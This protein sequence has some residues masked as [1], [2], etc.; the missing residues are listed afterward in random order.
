MVKNYF[1]TAWRNLKKSKVYSF[2][3]I[4]GLAIGMSV[5][6]IIGLWVWDELSFDKVHNNY[7]RIAQAWQFVKFDV[8]KSAYNSMPIPLAEELRTKYADFEAVSVSTYN[9]DVI[10][11]SGE[12]KIMRMGM[13]VEQDFP[14]MMTLKMR[15][16]VYNALSDMHSIFISQSLA[17]ALFATENPVNKI[18]RLNNKANVKI[19]GVYEDFPGNSSFKDVFFLAS[20]QLFTT[21]D[22]YA[23]Y[24]SDQWDE[25]SFQIFVQLKEGVDI[26]KLSA[27][28]K[29]IRMKRDNPPGYKPEFFLHPMSK[30][31]LHGDFQ[32]GVNTGGLIKIVRLFGFAGIFILLLACIN[33]MNLSTAR[34]EKRAKEVGIRKTL[35]SMRSQLVRQFFSESLLVS[36]IALLL[37]LIIAQLLLPFFNKIADKNMS[38]LWTNPIFWLSAIAFCLLAGLIAGSYPA[39]YLS[40][41]RPVKVLKGSFKAGRLASLPRKILVVFQ[42]TISVALI[43]GTIVVSRQI[44]F[45]KQRPTGYDNNGLIEVA[46]NTPDLKGHYEAIRA[47]LLNTGAV[48]AVSESMGYIVSDYGGTTNISWKGKLPDARPLI[49]RNA[50]THDFGKTIGWKIIEGRD[51]S[52]KFPTDTSAMILNQTAVQLM[53]FKDPLNEIVKVAGKDYRVIAVV[54]NIIK[55][56]PFESVKPSFFTINPGAVNVINIRLSAQS[57]VSNALNKIENVFK[58]YNPTAPFE[59]KFADDQY[60]AKF[61][62]EER[63]AKLAGFFAV[64]AIFISCLGL[65]GLASFVAEQRTK[66]I[67]IRKV[68]GA[69]II[70]VWQ[71]LSK[72]FLLLVFISL[73]IASPVAWYI[74]HN[75]LENYQYRVDLS[76][77]VF[78]IAACSALFITILTVSFHAIKAAIANPVKSLRTE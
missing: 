30:W 27:K 26:N 60:A 74:M 66:E 40:S 32:N 18:I 69:T 2:I 48:A 67:G 12:K 52:E 70:N 1:K 38:I 37:C 42:F 49:M 7:D 34:S 41:F 57:T 3:N 53:G 24:A 72:E 31:H 61:A 29:D 46:M 47:D 63:I 33:F 36:F 64:L 68:L 28:I 25:N 8:E 76:L 17:E 13:F 73:L 23:K 4:G 54:D 22:D 35:G 62:L 5:A 65:F 59:Y 51:F 6:M 39:L 21:M 56:S 19:A 58:K 44:N 9:R 78:V 16:G 77:W 71:L 10:L 14:K 43:I 20:W 45:A 75:W 55:G 15:S 50:I 11:T